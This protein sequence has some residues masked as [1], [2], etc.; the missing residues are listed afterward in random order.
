MVEI[1]PFG[2]NLL[3]EWLK[4]SAMRRF[5]EISRDIPVG[6]LRGG[7]AVFPSLS[8][9]LFFAPTMVVTFI[10]KKKRIKFQLENVTLGTT[11]WR[12]ISAN[13]GSTS[14]GN[15]ILSVIDHHFQ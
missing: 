15:M 3:I 13:E 11:P 2:D 1:S 10:K 9:F 14:K 8:L 6:L 5:E 12:E 4:V 7:G